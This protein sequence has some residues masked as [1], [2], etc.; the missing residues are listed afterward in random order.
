MPR[1]E[2]WGAE[3]VVVLRGGHRLRVVEA[4]SPGGEPVVLVPG[5][6]CPPYLF[7]RNIPA[8]AAAG[9]R[10]YAADLP[11]V[12]DEEEARDRSGYA[13]PA[14]AAQLLELLDALGVHRAALVGQSLGGAIATRVAL[15]APGRVRCLALLAPAG[16]GRL[17]HVQL[18]VALLR[19][20]L[21]PLLPWAAR[22]WVV[23]L[24]LR[25]AYGTLAEPLPEDVEQYWGRVRDPAA[26][27]AL[28]ALLLAVDWAPLGDE[29]LRALA[30]PLLVVHGDRDVLLDPQDVAARVARVPGAHRVEIAGAGH[31]VN[32]EAAPQVNPILVDFLAR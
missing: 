31:A 16:F 11:G 5:W 14:L 24:L 7:R 17:R 1:G 8:L 4:G 32:D 19:P 27:R 28:H 30:V 15:T 2:A 18:A 20:W 21:A 23:R 22:R 12:P 13:I 26:V 6:G 3:R 10:V 29:E 25:R 9:L